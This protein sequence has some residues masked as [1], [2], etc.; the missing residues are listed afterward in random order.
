MPSPTPAT[1]ARTT[2]ILTEITRRNYTTSLDGSYYGQFDPSGVTTDIRKK[3]R[4]DPTIALTLAAKKAPILDAFGNFSIHADSPKLQAFLQVVLSEVILEV[5]KSSLAAQ[6]FGHAP[7]EK[8]FERRDVTAKLYE[9]GKAG[10]GTGETMQVFRQAVV[11]KQIKDLEPWQTTYWFTPKGEFAAL[12]YGGFDGQW[13]PAMKAFIYTHDKEYGNLYGRSLLD[14]IYE[15]WFRGGI[16]EMFLMRYMEKKADPSI[17][18]FAPTSEVTQ[19]ADDTERAALE[20]AA[21]AISD[22]YRNSS[23][24]AIPSVFDPDTKNRLFDVELIEAE[25]RSELFMT[26]IAFY[27]VKKVR[28]LLCPERALIQSQDVGTNAEAQAHTGTFLRS[29]RIQLADL[30]KQFNRYLIPDLIRYNPT[31]AGP[32]AKARIEPAQVSLVAEDLLANVLQTA[33]RA[34]ATLARALIQNDPD[35][36]N[37]GRTLM[38]QMLDG[39]RAMQSLGLPIKPVADRLEIKATPKSKKE[40]TLPDKADE[41]DDQDEDEE[42]DAASEEN[43][44]DPFEDEDRLR[45]Y[46]QIALT[47]KGKPGLISE[48]ESIQVEEFLAQN[49]PK[50]R[51]KIKGPFWRPL[52]RWEQRAAKSLEKINDDLNTRRATY[53]AA[54]FAE[55]NRQKDTFIEH[56]RAAFGGGV[57]GVEKRLRQMPINESA[58]RQDTKIFQDQIRAAYSLGKETATGEIDF[59]RR[60]RDQEKALQAQQESKIDKAALAALLLFGSQVVADRH[61]NAR[62]NAIMATSVAY[63]ARR[64]NDEGALAKSEELAER[65]LAQHLAIGAGLI[66]TMAT[67]AY[68]RGLNRGREVVRE[69][70]EGTSQA[71][72]WAQYSA[73]L[74]ITTSPFGDYFDGRII[75]T[76][77]EDYGKLIPPNYENSRSVFIYVPAWSEQPTRS[78]LPKWADIP[79]EVRNYP[80]KGNFPEI[81]K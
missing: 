68:V 76:G 69:S 77:D 41:P 2:R 64:G 28:G 50:A 45:Y 67:T 11:Y 53:I 1:I 46:G 15:P 13:V 24:V 14:N 60:L 5:V 31:I 6:E 12:K 66:G 36:M 47:G 32:D 22:S 33:M 42:D 51:D 3:M 37:E 29:L 26:V 23:T 79:E 8:V 48:T 75:D 65:N 25:D 54:A 52:T 63:A 57:L 81:L 19:D 80:T 58:I 78:T 27:E 62:K 73:L 9:Q 21:K 30:T 35:A 39:A 55:W 17:K 74:N 71:V 18:V 49:G 34:E 10:Q 40:P 38:L 61:E 44:R 56:T 20:S 4:R 72:K 16:M 43:A 59:R 7:H 70:L